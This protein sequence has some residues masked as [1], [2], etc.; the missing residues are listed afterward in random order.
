MKKKRVLICGASGF[1]GKNISEK[2]SRRKDLEVLGICNQ[3]YRLVPKTGRVLNLGCYDLT[4]E[5]DINHLMDVT[6]PDVII[7]AAASTA[8]L[9]AVSKS[10]QSFFSPNVIMNTLLLDAAHDYHVRQFIFLSCPVMY[11]KD[12]VLVRETDVDTEKIHPKYLMGAWVKLFVENWGKAYSDLGRVK[13][14]AIRHP[15]IYGPY[16]K[17]NP[18]VAHVTGGKISEVMNSQ[19]GKV[20]VWGDGQEKRDLLY[21]SDLLDFIELVIDNQDYDFNIFNVG[22]GGSIS[23]IDLTKKIIE[24]SGRALEIDFDKT[25]PTVGVNWILDF[26]KAK[27]KFGWEPKVKLDEGIRKTIEWF[28]NNV[29]H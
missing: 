21:I 18:K 7:Q 12:M 20:Y 29:L 25:K 4:R 28:K 6:A 13:F 2:L 16:D 19:D 17:F 15:N 11:P 14:T 26:S 22:S 10:P 5:E 1:I 9:G 8:G 24:I 3:K 23:V 27:N